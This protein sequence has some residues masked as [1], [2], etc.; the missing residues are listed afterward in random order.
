MPDYPTDLN[1]IRDAAMGQSEGIKIDF[2]KRLND[3]AYPNKHF[4][5]LSARDWCEALLRATG[6]WKE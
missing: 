1:A 3:M 2:E 4:H 6:K 5:E